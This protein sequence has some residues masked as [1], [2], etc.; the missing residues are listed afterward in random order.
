MC[1]IIHTKRKELLKKRELAEAMRANSAGFFLAALRPDGTREVLRTLD[2]KAATAFWERQPSDMEMVMHFRI[3]SR[4][5]RNLENVHG[6]EEDG[7]LF[8][9][10]MTLTV[11]DS[12]MKRDKWDNTDSEYFFKKVFM[13]LYK[14]FGAEAY[15][16]GAL[17]EPLDRVVR[18]ICGGSN[19]FCFVMP[20][21]NVLRYGDWAGDDPSRKTPDGKP[22][23]FAS[24][25]SYRV[26]ERSYPSYPPYTG[27]KGGGSASADRFPNYSRDGFGRVI[28]DPDPSD[29]GYDEGYWG[30][31]GG[32]GGNEGAGCSDGQSG[33][34]SFRQP[35][36]H[37]TVEC[38]G[39][40]LRE[41]A[42][43]AGVLK[44][45]LA[46]LVMHNLVGYWETC[47]EKGAD[48]PFI[49]NM[50]AW[51]FPSQLNEDTYQAA[52][53]GFTDLATLKKP[54]AKEVEDF[55]GLYAG[56]LEKE[57]NRPEGKSSAFSP[58]TVDRKRVKDALEELAVNIGGWCRAANLHLDWNAP[59]GE[60]FPTAYVMEQSRRGRP[61]MDT[62]CWD[63]LVYA[64]D[65][66][67]EDA[68]A[69][70]EFLLRCIRKLEDAAAKARKD[71]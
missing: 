36:V 67:G 22:G 9:H 42:G 39:E 57:L 3:P 68:I 46:D 48:D 56:V 27:G 16:D 37:S 10:N 32:C 6:W 12:A 65:V 53:E 44:I 31:Y 50:N 19:R 20:D 58:V 54:G 60:E 21:N 24:N 17:C 63:D 59:S 14:A 7:I 47:S 51:F 2:E 26:Y 25:S 11:L 38:G 34:I 62:V 15:K 18:V 30:D 23:F 61:Y 49:D 29:P 35:E 33:K 4:G 69:T 8:S 28:Y 41:L 70:V 43:D 5:D 64:E 45:A 1:V 66:T 52:I 55:L 71:K 13:P 40:V